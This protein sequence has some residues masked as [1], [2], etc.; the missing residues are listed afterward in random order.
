SRVLRSRL[1]RVVKFRQPLRQSFRTAGKRRQRN[2]S[3]D[4]S[5]FE[6]RRD[7]FAARIADR[8]EETL[9]PNL[10]VRIK[11]STNIRRLLLKYANLE[12]V[13]LKASGRHKGDLSLS[14][15]R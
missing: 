11:I 7:S 4:S 9:I 3:A 6:R 5:R 8:D 13:P 14:R 12:H 10:A 1:N 2:Q 15:D